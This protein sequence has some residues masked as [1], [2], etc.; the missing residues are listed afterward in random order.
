MNALAEN[1]RTPLLDDSDE[2][3]IVAL[4]DGLP[5]VQQPYAAIGLECGL[6]E[7]EVIERIQRLCRSGLIKRFGII[8]RHRALGYRANAMLV[9]DVPDDEVDDLAKRMTRYPF[10]TLCYR[11]PRCLPDWPYNLFCMIH[12]RDRAD[13]N[14]QIEQLVRELALSTI[15]HDVLF[16]RRCFKQRGARYR[17][18]TG[19]P[20]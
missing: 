19:E 2:A 17:R 12:G 16:S 6:T 7:A 4:Q 15:S 14:L 20:N 9:W 8:V 3:L 11:R 1:L 13:V 18:L 10:I 5:L